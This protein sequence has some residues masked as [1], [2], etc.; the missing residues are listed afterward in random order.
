MHLVLPGG[1]PKVVLEYANGLADLGHEVCVILPYKLDAGDA[2]NFSGWL[3]YIFRKIGFPEGFKPEKWFKVN[4]KI[5]LLWVPT[6]N[7]QWI[8]DADIIIATFWQTAEIVA[9]YNTNKGM[10]F[11]LIQHDEGIFNENDPDRVRRTWSLPFKKIVIAKWLEELIAGRGENSIYIPNGLDNQAFY[12]DIPI[13]KRSPANLIMLWHPLKWKGSKQGLKTMFLIKK[14]V[15]E[16]RVKLF[17]AYEITE[18]FPSW[19]TYFRNP[20]QEILRRLYNNSA[21]YLGPSLVEGW[22]LTGCEAGLC[23]C[24]LCMTDIGGHREYAFDHKTALLSPPNDPEKMAENAVL[25]IRNN[26]LRIE[27]AKNVRAKLITYTWNKSI[28]AFH[29]LLMSA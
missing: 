27:L 21:I 22:G 25:L 12:I 6:L 3:K 19:I 5:R 7:E 10:K 23:G 26:E 11:Y 8:P 1:G 20:P 2:L 14:N 16:L 18:D 4:H 15:P 24:A 17:S 29:N 9:K 28:S 13:K